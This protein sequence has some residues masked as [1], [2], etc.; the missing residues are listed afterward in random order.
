MKNSKNIETMLVSIPVGGGT[1]VFLASTKSTFTWRLSVAAG[2]IPMDAHHSKEKGRLHSFSKHFWDFL[3]C[4]AR[5]QW[6]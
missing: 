3:E 2:R 1:G 5:H 6:W 4:S